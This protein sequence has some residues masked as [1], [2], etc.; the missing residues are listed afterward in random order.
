[1]KNLRTIGATLVV[2]ALAAAPLAAQTAFGQ[3]QWG[4]VSGG[5]S[6]YSNT[7]CGTT[8]T[9]SPSWTFYTSPYFAKF[10]VN[11]A[12]NN[13]PPSALLPAAG[14]NTFGPTNDIYCVDF[15][16]HALTGT[17]NVYYTNLG[18]NAGDIGTYTRSGTTLTQY[19]MAA[20]L[21]SQL[22]VYPNS[23]DEGN[24]NGAIWYIMDGGVAPL[25]RWNGTHWGNGGIGAWLTW[26]ATNWTSVNAYDWAVVTP[27]NAAG[28][29]NVLYN[30]NGSPN[31][32]TSAYD[33]NG[34]QEYIVNV[35]PEPATMLLLGTGLMLML[36]GAGAV[37]R[38][39]A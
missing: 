2:T 4:G 31:L 19:L 34:G 1:M 14:V 23:T 29:A 8:F 12:S 25:Y 13:V 18:S 36:M 15:F 10:S 7:N 26:A 30:T 9:C 39:S 11:S 37:R 6:S 24:I 5:S 38:L 17:S 33:N 21:A 3:M 27:T 32:A 20:A 28:K 35:T 22:S 16:D